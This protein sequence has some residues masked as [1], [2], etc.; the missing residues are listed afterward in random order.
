MSARSATSPAS[1]TREQRDATF[2]DVG[3]NSNSRKDGN[4][5][6]NDKEG[7]FT[8]AFHKRNKLSRTNLSRM[9]PSK[10]NLNKSRSRQGKEHEFV[11]EDLEKGDVIFQ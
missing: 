9:T 8:G 4:H 11:I 1:R 10:N 7:D 5:R 3:N 2:D 6:R